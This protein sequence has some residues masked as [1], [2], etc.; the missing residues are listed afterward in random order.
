MDTTKSIVVKK[1]GG[2][3][4]LSVEQFK[5]PPLED[6]IQ[7]QVE[8]GGVNF[9]DLYTRQGLM[10]DK[11]LPFVLGMECVGTITAIGSTKTDLKV[12]QR[13]ICYDYHG[14]MYRETV[15]VS[16]DKCYPLPDHIGTKEGAGIFV[17]YV[18][19]Y[20]SVM[21]LGNLKKNQ[22]ILL[23]SCG[24]GVGWAATQLAKTV[25]GV[26]I[27]G[28]TSSDKHAEVKTNGVDVALTITETFQKDV[29]EACPEGF[30]FILSNQSG[31]IFTFLQTLL[32]PLGRIVLI[33]ANNLIQNEQRLSAFSLIRAWLKTKNVSLEALITQNRVVAGL[34]L[35][36][37]IEKDPGKV[38]DALER[39]FKLLE[40]KKLA[41][42]IH[43]VHSMDNIVEATRLLA[44]RKNIGKVLICMKK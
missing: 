3:D 27:Y 25:E 29:Q 4:A 13:V 28:T 41:V 21:E 33:G 17:N 23:L 18:T 10:Y 44:E 40:E 30:D 19:A 7:V 37:L 15:H 16:E 6:K 34:H 5:L 24:G 11:K 39:I 20:F 12:G 1:F 42:R 36:T 35:G 32:K 31:P 2:Y 8:Y 26:K 22:T 43:S 14:G 38:K 9:A